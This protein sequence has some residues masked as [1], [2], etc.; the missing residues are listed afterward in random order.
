[1]KRLISLIAGMLMVIGCGIQEGHSGLSAQRSIQEESLR[2]DSD[3][4]MI[5]MQVWVDMMPSIGL[6]TGPTMRLQVRFLAP[7]FGCT[8]GDH[9]N[10]KLVQDQGKQILIIKRTLRDSCAEAMFRTE[11][12]HTVNGVYI[13]GKP[14]FM[15]GNEIPVFESVIN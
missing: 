6:G 12:N 8:T 14:V 15:N 9:F 7:S 3:I 13:P 10:A 11:I 2:S 5:S 4:Q 1:M